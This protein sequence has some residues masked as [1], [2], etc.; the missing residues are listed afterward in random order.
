[1]GYHWGRLACTAGSSSSGLTMSVPDDPDSRDQPSPSASFSLDPWTATYLVCQSLMHAHGKQLVPGDYQQPSAGAPMQSSSNVPDVDGTSAG[2]FDTPSTGGGSF[3]MRYPGRPFRTSEAAAATVGTGSGLP[4]PATVGQLPI[5]GHDRRGNESSATWT[6]SSGDLAGS[7]D[8]DDIQERSEFIQE[9]NR[10]ARKHGIRPLVAD[11]YTVETV[12]TPS[13]VGEEVSDLTPTQPDRSPLQQRRSWFS[14]TFLRQ[15]STASNASSARSDKKVKHKRSVSDLAMHLV[16][17]VKRDSLKDEDLQSLVR[18][19]GKSMLYLPSEYAP[20]SLIL[21]TCFRATAQYL[22]QHAADTQGVFRIPGSIRVVNAL[23]DYYCAEGD[24]DEISSTI[25]C[26]NLPLHIKASTHDVASTFKRLLAGL[27]G[28]ILGSLSLFDAL[29]A[30]HSQLKGDPEY[31]RTKQTKLRARLIALAVGTV[32]SQFRRELIS[33]VFG[34]LCLIG[35]TAEKTPREDDQGRPLPTA[36]LMGYNALGIV[37]GPLLVGDMI[38]TYTMKLANP[39]SGLVLF[40]VTP[41]NAKKERRK[42]KAFDEG[43]PRALSVDKIHV[44]NGIAE[45][46][47]IHWREVVKHMKSLEVLKT[48]RDGPGTLERRGS[49]KPGLRPSA[50]E[51][52]VIKKPAEWSSVGN[53]SSSFRPG[54]SPVPPSPTPEARR[55][56]GG[57]PGRHGT[58]RSSLLVQRQRPKIV[59]TRSSSQSRVGAKTSMPILSPTAEESPRADSESPKGHHAMDQMYGYP[60]PAIHFAAAMEEPRSL[61][62]SPPCKTGEVLMSSSNTGAALPSCQTGSSVAMETSL[63]IST[64]QNN[65][66]ASS[67]PSTLRRRLVVSKDSIRFTNDA[68]APSKARRGRLSQT[69]MQERDGSIAEQSRPGATSPNPGKE[70]TRKGSTGLTRSPAKNHRGKRSLQDVKSLK[71]ANGSGGASR[72]TPRPTVQTVEGLVSVTT[73]ADVENKTLRDDKPRVDI[74]KQKRSR[75]SAWRSRHRVTSTDTESSAPRSTSPQY[76]SF[77]G[78]KSQSESGPSLENRENKSSEI[79]IP[80]PDDQISPRGMGE[81][82]APRIPRKSIERGRSEGLGNKTPVSSTPQHSPSK[83]PDKRLLGFTPGP[84]G[85]LRPVKSVGSAV[86]AMAAMFES[87]SKEDAAFVPSPMQKVGNHANLKPSGVLAPYTINPSPKKS[88]SQ[89]PI[90]SAVK[91]ARSQSAHS[92]RRSLSVMPLRRSQGSAETLS[93]ATPSAGSPSDTAEKRVVGGEATARPVTPSDVASKSPSFVSLSQQLEGGSFDK[94]ESTRSGL[95]GSRGYHSSRSGTPAVPERRQDSQQLEVDIPGRGRSKY[96]QSYSRATGTNTTATTTEDERS[97]SR[98]R[99]GFTPLV[100]EEQQKPP[101]WTAQTHSRTPSLD[102]V[103][104]EDMS[105]VKWLALHAQIRSLQRQL[106]ARNEEVKHL[107]RELDAARDLD[108]ARLR[109][110]VIRTERECAMWR[111]RAEK[112]ERRVRMFERVAKAARAKY[113]AS[114]VGGVGNDGVAEDL[115]FLEDEDVYDEDEEQQSVSRYSESFGRVSSRDEVG[116]GREMFVERM[117]RAFRGMKQNVVSGSGEHVEEEEEEEEEE[118][119]G[120]G[121]SLRGGGGGRGDDMLDHQ[122]AMEM[123]PLNECRSSISDGGSKISVT[124]ASM[125]MAADEMF[126]GRGR[127]DEVIAE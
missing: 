92:S 102:P 77:R 43:H 98:S 69:G 9:Y 34:L 117:R 110:Q 115:D 7:S 1:M 37:F 124:A 2:S 64:Q 109:E 86:K 62:Q 55:G 41:P 72:D 91:S 101:P 19:C 113:A 119:G 99:Q 88:P 22:V 59:T 40:P 68:A 75:L 118:A 71:G 60:P 49:Q 63:D 125:W 32:R 57:G 114:S 84:P 56:S 38:N 81:E 45:M 89:S 93:A 13:P 51:S 23:Y 126:S 70:G 74:S 15:I 97:Q 36:D 80:S 25:R 112:A 120:E 21:P 127:R 95:E 83:S 87:A 20:C 82:S 18:L 16:N 42:S 76:L 66:G 17:V 48:S 123:S 73:P 46:L 39:N 96:R 106:E 8:T 65:G 79:P 50:S 67:S 90:R 44:A 12:S 6:S 27:P 26:P 58:A 33:A 30:I 31:P 29:V 35:R 10:L 94:G 24:A 111:E 14:R 28:G 105:R 107:R 4:H 61:R 121:V 116:V 104:Q 85:R 54:D 122:H 52:F 5:P 108:F 3:A 47:I 53:T 11:G 100:E 103:S 78:R